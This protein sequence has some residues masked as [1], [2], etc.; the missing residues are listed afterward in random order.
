M[1]RHRD[2]LARVPNHQRRIYAACMLGLDDGVGRLEGALREARL[3]NDTFFV[4][5]SDNGAVPTISQGGSNWPLRG[6]KLEVYEGGVRVPAFVHSP[7]L[8]RARRGA[9][10]AGL[11][12]ISDW[13][14]TLVEGLL[15]GEFALAGA[16]GLLADSYDQMDAIFGRGATPRETML[17][18][19]DGCDGTRAQGA[20]RV[21]DLKLVVE[22]ANTTWWP[23]P[24]S[25][26]PPHAFT[27]FGPAAPLV[28]A[29]LFN[30]SADPREERD[31]SR[32]RPDLVARLN[33][34]FE[35][36]ASVLADALYCP[37]QTGSGADDHIRVWREHN[38]TVGPWIQDPLY[39][40]EC[41]KLYCPAPSP[42]RAPTFT[43]YPTPFPSYAPTAPSSSAAAA[44][45]AIFAAD[46]GRP[47]GSDD[48][49]LA[50]GRGGAL[51]SDDAS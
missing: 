26:E 29:Q 21:G 36:F 13:A 7:L 8:P 15:G 2:A 19:A 27:A 17:V 10:Y 35:R 43:P 31:L 18:N 12:H 24:T 41:S 16:D 39:Q 51:P 50:G 9:R 11:M 5:T 34:T 49:T 42:T 14:R 40:Y 38:S 20:V 47:H 44:D 1:E 3:W 28:G 25:A 30:L 33:A 48:T 23:V 45:A 32:A 4:F 46:G 37:I 22:S 6:Q